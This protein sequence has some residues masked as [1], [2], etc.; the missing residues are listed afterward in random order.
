MTERFTPPIRALFLDLDGVLWRGSQPI[1]D[2]P[3]IFARIA[4]LGLRVMLLTNNATRLVADVQ[5]KLAGYGVSVTPE[6]IVTSA[7]AAAFLLRQH[8]PVG[9]KVYVVGEEGLRVP[10][11]QAGFVVSEDDAAAVVAGLDRTLTYEKVRKASLLIRGGALFVGSNPDRTFPAPEGL[12]PGAGAVLAA[13]EAASGVSP[14][15]AGK[16]QPALFQVALERIRV[17]AAETLMVGDRLDTDIL[18]G[19]LAGCQT[20]LVLT[21]VS[22]LEEASRW[23]PPPDHI[24]ATL[25]DLLDDLEMSS[26]D[27]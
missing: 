26:Y 21:G 6:Q 20:A 16:P 7:Q 19:Q 17:P 11:E 23:S 5:E 24:A 25:S 2:L 4:R 3:A 18:G 22:T 1:G 8:L 15:I 10:V 14:L 27:G 12:V 9:S 13:I